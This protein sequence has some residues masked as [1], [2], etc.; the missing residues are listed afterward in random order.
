MNW[1]IIPVTGLI[2]W[3]LTKAFLPAFF[4]NNLKK[5]N[6]MA[7]LNALELAEMSKSLTDTQR[8]IF[9]QQYSSEKKERG[10]V[11]ILAI[12]C[13]DR[14]WLGDMTLGILKY[15]TLGG[16]GIWWLIDLFTAA[17]RADDLNRRK[18]REIID[19]IQV[20]ARS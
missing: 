16:C 7:E 18:A 20:S 1:L 3:Q 5:I 6:L 2:A 15:L 11:V 14:F 19:G 12:L 4:S 13:Y 10:T 9:N 8:M 17:D